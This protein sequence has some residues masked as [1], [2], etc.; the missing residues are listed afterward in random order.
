[1]SGIVGIF[2]RDGAPVERSLLQ[3]LTRSLAYR[4]PDGRETWTAGSI[5][6]GHTLLRTTAECVAER[7]PASLDGRFWITADARIDCRKELQLELEKKDR[8]V[9]RTASDSELILHAYAA[10]GEA[11][12]EHLR[13][14]FAFGIWDA[15]ERTLFCARDHFGVK[16]FYYASFDDVFVFSNTLDCVRAHPDVVEELDDTAIADFLLFGVNCNKAGTTFR[17]IHRLPPAHCLTVS[18]KAVRATRYWSLPVD[19]RIRYR[20]AD[21][22]VEHFQ[23]LLHAAVADRLRTNR[24]GILLSG[25]L[26]SSSLAATARELSASSSGAPELRAYTV[27]Y[28]S[29]LPDRDGEYA[30]NVAEFLR[31]PIRCLP[32]DGLQLFERWNDPELAWPEPVEDPFFAALF[33]QYG[34]IAADC[35]VVLEGEGID[36]LM[37]FE[38]WPYARHLLRS[39]E[40]ANLFVQGLRY[41]QARKSLWPGIRRRVRA[42]FGKGAENGGI[43]EWLAPDFARRVGVEDRWRECSDFRVTPAHPTAPRAHASMSLPEWCQLFELENAGVT[44]S[45]VEVRHPYLDLRIVNY[46][47]ALPRFPWAFEKTLL[48]EAMAGHLP[49]SIRRRPK[50]PFAGSI[51]VEKLKRPEASWID[52]V[53]WD[54]QIRSYVNCPEVP[55]LRGEENPVRARVA[56]RPLCLNFWLQCAR[57]LRY[58]FQAEVRNA[59]AG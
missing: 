13:G 33:D 45:P 51:L 41:W 52:R 42:V 10:W 5:G 18:A 20:R 50:T 4:G 49:E 59:E 26:D 7:Q 44:R 46:V 21:E 35:R 1:M 15:R 9:R 14:D 11:C 53:N 29:L 57:R 24:A 25:G 2:Q 32:M 37:G 55:E 16:P 43:P 17:D 30:R 34:A 22:Y 48:R 19:G 58:N 36:N 56:I 47:F 3:F 28:E 12:V 38:M 6:L 39:R 40:W 23:V 54:G 8:N 31:I 27:T